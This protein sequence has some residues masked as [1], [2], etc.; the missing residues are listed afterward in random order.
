MRRSRDASFSMLRASLPAIG[1]QP[2]VLPW[3]DRMVAT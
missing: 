3:F 1:V 2:V